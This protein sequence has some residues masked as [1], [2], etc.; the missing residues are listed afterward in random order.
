[1]GNSSAL[2][3]VLTDPSVWTGQNGVTGIN[4]I[5][6][7]QNLQ[8]LMQ[9]DLMRAGYQQLQRTG[10]INLGSPPTVV[11]PLVQSSVRFGPA[12]VTQWVGGQANQLVVN[13]INALAKNAQ[14]A[15]SVVTNKLG[16]GNFGGI[17]A[18]IAG[19]T[20]TVSRNVV[21]SAV[22]NVIDNPKVPPPEFDPKD[23]TI[24]ID[25]RAEQQDARVAAYEQARREGKSE[26]EAQNISAR[27]GNNVGSAA[28]AREFG[29]TG[30]G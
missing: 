24:R 23:R 14:Q 5:L 30:L 17:I 6:N 22:V 20:Q 21:N 16:L 29:R 27:V 1:L 11:A 13:Q 12:A 3:A 18:A 2:N 28:L 7:N 19:V 26:A 8:A 25:V 10:V 9:Q 4:G 15:I